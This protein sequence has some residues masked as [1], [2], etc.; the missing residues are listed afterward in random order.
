VK[1]TLLLKLIPFEVERAFC[2]KLNTFLKVRPSSAPFL[3]GDTYRALT[4]YRYDETSSFDP[5]RLEPRSILFVSSIRLVEFVTQALPMIKVPFVLITHQGD[6]N[7]GT[8]FQDLAEN[9]MLLHWFAQNCLLEHTK[10][11]SLPIGLEDRWRHN[12]GEVRHFRRLMKKNTPTI[13][14]IAFGFSI[15]TN[16]EKRVACYRALRTAKVAVELPQYLSGR[17]YRNTVSRYMFIASPPGNGLDCHRTWEAL[18]MGCIPIVEDN[19]MNREF[20]KMGFPLVLVVDWNIIK[21]WKEEELRMR[22]EDLRRRT[23]LD[24]MFAPWWE[25]AFSS[26]AR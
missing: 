25:R 5:S 18:Y 12:N 1:L 16:L 20:L 19:Y 24:A 22:Y 10:V 9:P 15:G 17:V 21:D 26:F 14:R 23:K 13:P 2:S 4:D 3:S 8:E 11:T 6:V 7:I